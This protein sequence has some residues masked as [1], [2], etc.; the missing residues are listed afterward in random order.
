[1]YAVSFP[2]HYY[3][4]FLCLFILLFFKR[5]SS[6]NALV[7]LCLLLAVNIAAVVSDYYRPSPIVFYTLVNIY[8][9]VGFAS[10]LGFELYATVLG[11]RPLLTAAGP[12]PPQEA[13][14]QVVKRRQRPRQSRTRAK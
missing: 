13:P 5:P 14:R 7:P 6:L 9:F 11:K 4:T 12:E 8:L 2:S 1:V 10:I 3:Y